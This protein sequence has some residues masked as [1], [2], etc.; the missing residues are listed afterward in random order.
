MN[1]IDWL[2]NVAGAGGYFPW[3]IAQ[4]T[5][6]ILAIIVG[7]GLAFMI[8]GILLANNYLTA[9]E[10]IAN[11]LVGTFKFMFLAQVFTGLMAFIMVEA[12]NRYRNAESYVH[13]EV[14]A[15]RLLSQAVAQMPLENRT[16]FHD[17]VANYAKSVAETEW[18]TM[19][20]GN[21]SPIA[22]S[23]FQKV[24]AA[25]FSFNP[26]D[27]RDRSVVAFGNQAVAMMVEART[28]RI[29]NNVA[30]EFSDFTWFSLLALV[31]VT[32]MFNWFFGTRGLRSQVAMGVVLGVSILSCVFIVFLLGNPY[33]GATAISSAPF[34]ELAR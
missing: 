30:R 16:R 9:D 15:V 24:L 33:A 11:T 23:A 3:L 2:P 25:Y 8:A 32:A 20:Q 29:N 7:G 34:L 28:N 5:A 18:A 6:T 12:G 1:G 10:L 13:E 31:A 27:L 19:A 22:D 26:V 4:P 21:E 14:A 17:A